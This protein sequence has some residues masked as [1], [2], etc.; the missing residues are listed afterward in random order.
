MQSPDCKL[1]VEEGQAREAKLAHLR[2]AS[3]QLGVPRQTFGFG[4]PAR[5]LPL[6]LGSSTSTSVL[7]ALSEGCFSSD[8]SAQRGANSGSLER[9]LARLTCFVH[10]HF[11][12]YC[13]GGGV[14]HVDRQCSI[15]CFSCG[16]WLRCCL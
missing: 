8:C 14:T 15:L 1:S 16:C 4:P 11:V 5:Y 12:S 3:A 13:T 2:W 7:P 9:R 10:A 6:S